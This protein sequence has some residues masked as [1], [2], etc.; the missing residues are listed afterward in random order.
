MSTKLRIADMEIDELM[1]NGGGDAIRELSFQE[2]KYDFEENTVVQ[3]IVA[4]TVK[5]FDITSI[6]AFGPTYYNHNATFDMPTDISFLSTMELHK[7]T[8]FFKINNDYLYSSIEYDR[9]IADK[10]HRMIP[11]V[12]LSTVSSQNMKEVDNFTPFS[13][14]INSKKIKNFNTDLE[15]HYVGSDG[16]IVQKRSRVFFGSEY[17]FGIGNSSLSEFPYHNK[18]I[19]SAV[20]E[21][22]ILSILKDPRIDLYD[23]IIND[24]LEYPKSGTT[25]E[26]G[27]VERDANSVDLFNLIGQGNSSFSNDQ[28]LVMPPYEEKST[29]E[30]ESARWAANLNIKSAALLASRNLG[31]IYDEEQAGYEWLFFKIE[32]YAGNNTNVSPVQ[33]YIVADTTGDVILADTQIK[34]MEE[35]TYIVMGYALVKGSEYS[36]RLADTRE[37][38]EETRFEIDVV[39]KPSMKILELPLFRKSVFVTKKPPIP[40]YV[41]FINKSNSKSKIKILLDL[42]RGEQTSKFVSVHEKDSQI[43][44]FLP[45]IE[46]D[47]DVE[48]EY[49]EHPGKFEIFKSF[50]KIT[51][52]NRYDTSF[53]AENAAGMPYVVIDEKIR[54]NKKYY[55]FFRTIND[56]GLPSNPSPIYEIELLKDSDDSKI[57]VNIIK[58]NNEIDS[59]FQPDVKFG[60][61]LHVLPAFAQ[62]QIVYPP[63]YNGET[64]KKLLPKFNLG[65]AAEPVWGRKFKFRI[66]STNTGR[67]IDF[68]IIFDIVKRE[69]EENLK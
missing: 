22:T 30:E 40:P 62:S 56:F 39:I 33:T 16:A 45:G 53:I 65:Y 58:V 67:K 18:I 38:E 35:Y 44:N 47:K 69:S 59:R 13:T 61:F 12:Y 1:L 23:K 3:R 37:S 27:G 68:N 5:G 64:Y 11:T 41:K 32:K 25:F 51:N 9:F 49:S 63:E 48:F 66:T 54:A 55:Y 52:Y 6:M 4:T 43:M 60:Q 28:M 7:Q 8:N 21:Q 17:S 57:V 26:I 10:D 24:Y 15:S 34:P 46:E 36:Y 42:Q 31:E 14:S 20:K 19:F 2:E 50:D 29:M